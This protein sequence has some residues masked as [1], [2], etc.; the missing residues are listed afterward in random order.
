MKK[1]T[2][3]LEGVISISSKGTGY[4]A[5]GLDKNKGQDP[6]VDFKHL[7]TAMHGD[8]VEIILHPK[9]KNR[10][11]AEVSRIVKRA[12][13]SFAGILEKHDSVF[14][15]KPDDT[16]MYTDILIQDK[17]LG[18]AKAGEKVFAEITSWADPKKAPLGKVLRVLGKPGD[19][20]VEMESIAIEKGFAATLPDKV[21]EEAR[22]IKAAGIKESDYKDRKDFRKTLTFTIDPYDAKDFDDAISFKEVGKEEYERRT[23]A[24]G[25]I[26][27][28]KLSQYEAADNTTGAKEFACVSGVCEV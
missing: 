23:K 3:L 24:I 26:D 10:Q 25:K 21:E 6:E 8:T 27:F 13:M 9:G 7:N 14:F 19:N 1:Q 28:S 18:G 12:K 11:T 5:I 4:V 15:L 16:K 20:N 17:D 2:K 22:K